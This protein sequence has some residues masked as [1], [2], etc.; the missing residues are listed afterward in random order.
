MERSGRNSDLFGR[1][2]ELFV[3]LEGDKGKVK[4]RAIKDDLLGFCL[5][6]FDRWQRYATETGNPTRD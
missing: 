5:S 4:E 2:N 3:V 1:Q 6:Q